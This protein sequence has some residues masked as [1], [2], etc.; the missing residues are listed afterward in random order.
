MLNSYRNGKSID[1]DLQ[2]AAHQ[3]RE[4]LCQYGAVDASADTDQ[5]FG[6]FTDN[7]DLE[8]A[9]TDDDD[10][11][12]F[13]DDVPASDTSVNEPALSTNDN[14][15]ND[16]AKAGV[17]TAVTPIAVTPA[18]TTAAA[19]ISKSPSISESNSIRVSVEKTDQL[20]NLVGELVITQAMLD[21]LGGEIETPY[22]ERLQRALG[23]LSRNTRQL[24]EAAMSLRMLPINQIFSRFPRLVRD[25]AGRLQ[26]DVELVM[27]GE[28]TELDKGLV[29]KLADPLTH[30]VRNSID[31]GI[32]TIDDRIAAGK[33]ARGTLR[34][35]AFHQGGNIVIEVHDDG[36]GLQREK[37]LAKASERGLPAHADMSDAEVWQLIFEPGFS[38]AAAIT[39]V[40]GR[41]VGM[42]VVRRN[43]AA[44][45]G[46]VEL[47]SWAGQGSRVRIRLPLTLAILDGMLVQVGAQIYVVP[48]ASIVE[49]L[50]PK[51]EC[52]NTVAGGGRVIRVRGEY[53]P[54][55]ALHDLFNES[56]QYRNASE[57]IVVILEASSGT[58]AL[59]VDA[60]AGQSQVV[61]KSLET[62]YRRV[63][64]FAGATILGSGQ[65]AMIL[66][67]DDLLRMSQLNINSAPLTQV[68]TPQINVA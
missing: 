27:E 24:Q 38:T 21:Q 13:F 19:A 7:I 68:S 59:Q 29:E 50:Q 63:A 51:V 6:F 61:I 43:I 55:V 17:N 66:D 44:M 20:I 2:T 45:S 35:K 37:I 64:G 9:S 60:L 41:G 40:S 5:G 16:I 48:L 4:K 54:L 36:R 14:S 3:V 22:I 52:I 67:I 62:N 65:V 31:H 39:D 56:P 47:E 10:S 11:F 42:D 57:A 58:F 28:H 34:L 8:K 32:E 46:R 12:G 15:A 1:A 25:L 53:I 30:I 33:P 49:S 23:Q 18:I 26:K